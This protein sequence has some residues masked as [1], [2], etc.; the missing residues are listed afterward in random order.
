MHLIA[1]TFP[2]FIVVPNPATLL[3]LEPM[4]APP[5]LLEGTTP[6]PQ[7]AGKQQ[8][9]GLVLGGG[10]PSLPHEF[11]K[12][13]ANHEYVELGDLL[14]E[15][16]QEASLFPEGKLRRRSSPIE[17]FVDWVLA[18][19]TYSHGLLAKNPAIAA[20]LITFMGTVARL[21]RDHPGMAWSAYERNFR[22]NMTAD[23]S[24]SWKKLDQEVWALAMVGQPG[25]GHGSSVSGSSSAPP[26]YNPA[27]NPPNARKRSTAQVC[28][29]WNEGKF[30]PFK[31]CPYSH[32]CSTCFSPQHR[33]TSCFSSVNKK[34]N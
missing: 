22:A 14:P 15:R 5:T 9:M 31:T 23:H 34:K 27:Y 30:C 16:I 7:L 6:N 20:E 33:A 4:L 3:G 18:F 8:N 1:G 29:V 13:I 17:K 19:S 26:S 25:I 2:L 10:L 11:V 28:R 12:K 21:A 32:V 24:L